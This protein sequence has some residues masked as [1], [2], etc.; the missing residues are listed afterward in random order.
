MTRRVGN[1]NAEKVKMEEEEDDTEEAR[2]C[3]MTTMAEEDTEGFLFLSCAFAS[4]LA[5]LPTAAPW[6]VDPDS[7]S[8]PTTPHDCDYDCT[9]KVEA[10]SLKPPSCFLCQHGSSLDVDEFR[11][12]TPTQDADETTAPN[13]GPGE[14]TGTDLMGQDYQDETVPGLDE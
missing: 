11:N 8:C 4:A 6:A 13:Q 9:D 7:H 5:S 2:R 10:S 1:G 14:I 3:M 12:T